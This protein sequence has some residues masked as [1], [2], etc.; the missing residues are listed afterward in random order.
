MMMMIAIMTILLMKMMMT[1]FMMIRM[2]IGMIKM[3]TM[4]WPYD[5]F[6]LPLFHCRFCLVG[7]SVPLVIE[8]LSK[9][10]CEAGRK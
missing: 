9:K 5:S 8:M 7:Y 3:N 1:T 2:M 6:C 4:G 10:V